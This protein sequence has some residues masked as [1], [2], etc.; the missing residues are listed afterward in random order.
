MHIRS[1]QMFLIVAV[2]SCLHTLEAAD[3]T[4]PIP[5]RKDKAL[6]ETLLGRLKQA[7]LA[8]FKLKKVPLK[9]AFIHLKDQMKRIDPTGRG[10]NI[11]YKCKKET[12]LR[13]ISIDIRDTPIS[14]LVYFLCMKA[15]LNYRVEKYAII[16]WDIKKGEKMNKY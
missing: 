4:Q 16:V 8:H 12:K 6:E 10:F 1:I 2:L 7:K 11:L 3:E 5:I 9:A 15:Q 13:S 14:E